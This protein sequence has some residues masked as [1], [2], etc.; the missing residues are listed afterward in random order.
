MFDIFLC[1]NYYFVPIALKIVPPPVQ[2]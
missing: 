1:Q 2:F